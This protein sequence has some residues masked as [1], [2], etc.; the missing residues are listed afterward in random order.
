M[1][2][3]KNISVL[4]KTSLHTCASRENCTNFILK[5]KNIDST[6]TR[7][8][9]NSWMWQRPKP[10]KGEYRL[11]NYDYLLVLD[12]EATC[13]DKGYEPKPQEIIEFPCAMLS[14]ERNFEVVS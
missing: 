9:S 2:L 10:Q 4:F 1:L 14:T 8:Q 13:G 11:Q 6:T 12:F 5:C 7:N 3:M